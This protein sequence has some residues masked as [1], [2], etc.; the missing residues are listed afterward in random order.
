M[1]VLK[2]IL[3]SVPSTVA[4]RISLS[5]SGASTRITRADCKYKL[6]VSMSPNLVSFVSRSEP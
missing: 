6:S 3:R 5:A 1:V 4:L 2:S